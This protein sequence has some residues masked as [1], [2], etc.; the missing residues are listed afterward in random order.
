MFEPAHRVFVGP[1]AA[2]TGVLPGTIFTAPFRILARSMIRLRVLGALDLRDGQGRSIDPVLAQP[3]RLALLV[4][5][6]LARPY[7][8]QRR[9][10][11]VASL[12]PELDQ[13][14]A[15]NAL[16]QAL[17]H[18]RRSLG[19]DA[20]A[21]RG[22]EEIG[23]ADDK[24]WCDARSFM[25]AI[26]DGLI[27]D[28]LDTYA[29][30]LLPGFFVP[31]ASGFERWLDDER[32]RLRSRAA[33]AAWRR[34]DNLAMG[35]DASK[36]T[37]WARYAAA[38]AP[39]DE[40]SQRHLIAL[41]AHVG[42]RAGALRSFDEF[43]RRLADEYGVEP[44]A[45][46]LEVV[47]SLRARTVASQSI[48]V[49][50]SD[51]M[52]PPPLDNETIEP[53]SDET[54]STRPTQHARRRRWAVPVGVIAS[55][56][57]LGFAYRVTRTENPPT[58]PGASIAVLPFLDLGP[59]RDD[60]YLS[61]GMAE[62]LS[63]ALSQIPGLRVT[64]RTSAFA[65]RGQPL[66]AR[67]I[68][69]ALGVSTLLEGSVRRENSTLRVTA[70]LIDTRTGYH[71]WSRTYDRE[72]KDVFAVQDDI[73]RAIVGELAIQLAG[74][75]AASGSMARHPTHNL[76]AYTLYLQG[77]YFW[78][79]RTASALEKA[80]S[81]FERAIAA[82]RAYGSAYAGLADAYNV[83]AGQTYLSPAD[84]FPKAKAA[85]TRAL[86]LDSTLAE[87]HAA[88]G[89]IHLFNEWDG[90][91]A[92]RELDRAIAIDPN[93]S[94]ARLYKAFLLVSTGRATEAV[95][96]IRRAQLL[97]PLSRIINARVGFLLVLARR[98][99][100]AIDAEAHAIELDSTNGPA[101]WSLGT[102]HA[103]QRR[104]ELA[105]QDYARARALSGLMLGEEGYSYARSGDVKQAKAFLMS[106]DERARTT[107]VDPYERALVYAGLGDRDRALD[108]L[109]RARQ[110]HSASI[111]WL[112]TEPMLD[113]LRGDPRF[114]ALIREV[115]L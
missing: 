84:A 83:M 91:A 112:R 85:A 105:A 66:D 56:A 110:A 8:L 32:I 29:G 37:H 97:D 89:F 10:S 44:S 64:S 13:P 25:T 99:D 107:Y 65:F 104:F 31:D 50:A 114:A 115:G 87:S 39:D 95:D 60:A 61:D 113:G 58:D 12:W 82:D 69:R 53:T 40:D 33:V 78:N 17:H 23:I 42:D 101:Y 51:P 68:G 70:Q 5:L 15:R 90:A 49:G 106:L 79:E 20:F 62:E 59:G 74:T 26:D 94:S 57:L 24:L 93:Y 28:A 98:F 80:I 111:I 67:A 102:A 4:Y 86:A 81:F 41:L 100:E 45:E 75:P 21:A 27:D 92:Q 9:D 47:R 22:D 6:A 73:A 35:G 18:L 16:S 14:R 11:L 38:L 1:D 103:A 3:K 55:V 19:S 109:N 96:E 108:W 54:E 2:L 43:A 7:G 48:K 34:A 88:L 46:T 76:E 30:D 77:R 52:P 72:L 36:A 71:R 63:D